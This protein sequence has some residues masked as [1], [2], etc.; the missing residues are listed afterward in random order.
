MKP[1]PR[2]YKLYLTQ[3]N[4]DWCFT[5][6]VWKSLCKSDLM[7][8]NLYLVWP[9]FLTLRML[10]CT[11]DLHWNTWIDDS[12]DTPVWLT[13]NVLEKK[14]RNGQVGKMC[15][16]ALNEVGFEIFHVNCT[17]HNMLVLWGGGRHKKFPTSTKASML[18]NTLASVLRRWRVKS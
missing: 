5:Q 4:L 17:F 7:G 11:I 8:Y 2:K 9:W 13:D 18:W 1:C 3:S 16:L 6:L 14:E 15:S 12:A 10:S